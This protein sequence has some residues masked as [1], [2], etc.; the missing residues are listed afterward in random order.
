MQYRKLGRTGLKVSAVSLGSMVFGDQVSEAE[1]VG[2]I[3]GALDSGVNFFDTA[4][5]YGR[6]RAEEIMGK[7]LKECRQSIILAT[8]VG[9]PVGPAVN[10][11]GLSR[12]HVMDGIAG[13]LRRLGTDYVDVL[14]M[15][16][17]D[18]DTPFEETLRAFDDLVRDGKVRYIGCCNIRA[19][20]LCRSL[21]LSDI[22]H[23]ARFNSVQPPYN[24][25]TRDVEYELLPL[26]QSE[27]LGVCVYNPLAAGLLTGKYRRDEAPAPGTR[28][29]HETW[30]KLYTGRYWSDTNFKA[31]EALQQIAKENGLSLPQF[32]FAWLLNNK[33][34]TSVICGASSVRHLEENIKAIDVKL[35]KESLAACDNVWRQIRP[36][37]YFYADF[38][39]T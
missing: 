39:V 24:L 25:L 28:F 34:V 13:S 33:T 14:Y 17:V 6:G 35:S 11:R 26:C 12:K 4:D 20:Q 23:L 7:A 3:K 22:H 2:I 10:E 21:W 19:W 9:G 36:P 8:K 15:H 16:Y 37:R 18:Y 31:V 27:E 32:A 29:T 30:G 5:I 38:L 1:A